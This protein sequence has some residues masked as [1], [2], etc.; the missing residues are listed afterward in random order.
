MPEAHKPDHLN[1]TRRKFLGGAVVG[2]ALMGTVLTAQPASAASKMSQK[3]AQY[4]PT[5]N[6]KQRCDNCA[7]WE[8][9]SSCRLVDGPISPSGWCMIYRPKG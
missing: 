2:G 3:A 7:F 8:P 6:G 5:P 1:L 9:P 4:R